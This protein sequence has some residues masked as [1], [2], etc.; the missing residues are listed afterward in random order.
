MT[1]AAGLCLAVGAMIYNFVD[2]GKKKGGAFQYT[3]I[4][5]IL[6]PR[7]DSIGRHF[8]RGDE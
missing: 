8:S 6:A 5:S 4:N 1:Q 3:D 2:K 7:A